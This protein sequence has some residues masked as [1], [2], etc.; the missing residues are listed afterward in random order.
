MFLDTTLMN[1]CGGEHSTQR[2]K[3]MKIQFWRMTPTLLLAF[4]APYFCLTVISAD[5]G[6]TDDTG[7]CLSFPVIW[8]DGESKALRGEFNTTILQGNWWYHWGTDINGDP[9]SCAP[10]PDDTTYCNDGNWGSIGALPGEGATRAHLQQDPLNEWQAESIYANAPLD[11]H[12]IDWGDNL[13]AVDWYLK[14]MVRTEVVLYQDLY[15]NATMLEYE[16]RHLFGWG[17]DEMHGVATTHQGDNSSANTLP[18]EQATVYTQCA[19]LTIQKLLFEREDPCLNYLIWQGAAGWTNPQTDSSDGVCSTQLIN[20]P[21]YNQAVH[22]AED[23]RGYYAAE[24]NVKGKVIFGYTWNVRK[25]NDGAGDYRITFSID[26]AADC[27]VEQLNT[28]FTEGVTEILLPDEEDVTLLS[29]TGEAPVG[30]GEAKLDFNNNLT[31][32][33]VRILERV[34]GKKR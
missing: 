28:Y 32:I 25:L 20:T 31:Y 22:E 1:G 4:T 5:A 21:L 7:N 9:L 17:V 34:N 8:S 29:D 15:A 3:I 6:G 2:G 16:M 33:D 30:G 13:E 18:G 11:V 10:D 14:S 12:Y 23:G 19:R 26:S 24:I 27:N